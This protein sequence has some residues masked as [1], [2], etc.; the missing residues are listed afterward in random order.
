M[1]TDGTANTVLAEFPTQLNKASSNYIG[2]G[3]AS[4]QTAAEI[5][6]CSGKLGG[7]DA[8]NAILSRVLVDGDNSEATM[9]AIAT[10][11]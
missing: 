4:T 2:V 1:E 10:E 8:F 6:E 7:A 11:Q 3:G 5:L 9:L